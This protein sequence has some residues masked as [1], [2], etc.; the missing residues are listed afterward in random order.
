M[1]RFTLQYLKCK[2]F[3]Q[4]AALFFF[5]FFTSPHVHCD[6]KSLD[7]WV[8][9]FLYVCRR[10]TNLHKWK[11]FRKRRKIRVTVKR[12]WISISIGGFVSISIGIDCCYTWAAIKFHIC[13]RVWQQKAD[14]RPQITEMMIHTGLASSHYLCVWQNMVGRV[15]AVEFL[16][17]KSWTWQIDTGLRSQMT[18][19]MILNH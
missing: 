2:P 5:F 18:S 9:F 6:C 3:Q 19:I 11:H 4:S 10:L 15:F 7:S 1:Q 13:W 14:V 12:N 16:L 8:F 17:Y